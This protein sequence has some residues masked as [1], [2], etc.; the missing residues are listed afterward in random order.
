M[1]CA[2]DKECDDVIARVPYTMGSRH[3]IVRKWAARFN[4][5]EEFLRV[6]PLWVK[7]P[8]LPLHYWG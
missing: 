4:C 1:Q 3:V 6:L 5:K 7:L 8:N 2:F